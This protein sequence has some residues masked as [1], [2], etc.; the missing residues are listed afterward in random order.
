M[1][2]SCHG[3][4]WTAEERIV[5]EPRVY[6]RAFASV[7]TGCKTPQTRKNSG[8]HLHAHTKCGGSPPGRA[9]AGLDDY[10]CYY[11]AG[12][13]MITTAVGP[14]GENLQAAARANE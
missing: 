9:V 4:A 2:A 3:A 1:S 5:A 12:G 11:T 10:R 7:G 13:V 6:P 14:G 8:A